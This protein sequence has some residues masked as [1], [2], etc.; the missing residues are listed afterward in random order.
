M[1]CQKCAIM[2]KMKNKKRKQHK[3]E[4]LLPLISPEIARGIVIVILF[5]FAV[6]SFLS[7][8]NSAGVAGFYLNKVLNIAFGW[9]KYLFAALCLG[10][11]YILT[12]P[13]KYPIHWH[14]YFG[15]LLLLLGVGGIIHLVEIDREQSFQ[16]VANGLGAGFVGFVGSYFLQTYFGMVASM[17]ILIAVVF[18]SII[19]AFNISLHKI[20]DKEFI[21][22]KLAALKSPSENITEPTGNVA[23]EVDD[24]EEYGAPA[25]QFVK[26]QLPQE[27]SV[28]IR[29]RK[30]KIDLPIDLLDN[31]IEKPRSGDVQAAKERI[32]KTLANFNIPVEMA[33]ISVGPTV[34][35]YTLKPA[36]GIKLSKITTLSSDLAL[37]LAAHPIRIEA[38]IPGKSLVGIEVPNQKIA[39]VHIRELL[40]NPD[41]KHRQ[42]SLTIALGKDVAGKPQFANL[43]K[44]PHLLI[45]GATGSGKSMGIHSMIIT[46]L[47][48][49]N[50]ETL[51]LLLVDPKR[52][53]FTAYNGIPHLLTPVITDVTKTINALRWAI[54]EMDR[55]FNILAK[56]HKRNVDSYNLTAAEKMPY[57]V[58]VIDE[59]ADLMVA[60]PAEVEACVIRLTQMARAVG[61]HLIIATQRPSVDVITGLIK[62]NMPTRIA[63]S[64]ASL[65][66]SRTILDGS[67]AEKLMGKGDML[68]MSPLLSKPKRLQGGFASD[69]EIKR[70]T[71]FLKDA[72][73]SEQNY[74]EEILEKQHGVSSMDFYS[75]A[76]D[77]DGDVLFNDAKEVVIQAGRA[78]ASLLQRRLRVGYA[79][80]ARLIDLM[81]AAGI[82]GPADGARPRDVLVDSLQELPSQR[83]YSEIVEQQDATPFKSRTIAPIQA[84]DDSD[85]MIEEVEEDEDKK[86]LEDLD[87]D[88][89]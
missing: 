29:P 62:A 64:V 55:R 57:I 56:N 72:S 75:S 38:P 73:G 33:D 8:V 89:I 16:A 83:I 22:E 40:E 32:Q 24:D 59:L 9:T 26:R 71:K 11:S 23:E 28:M 13:T 34:T 39:T 52:V 45:A 37:A 54:S 79:R 35:Q 65:I 86:L 68:F 58:I 25:A 21:A 66:D 3:E 27:Q 41:F 10:L 30:I 12:R 31:K 60:A 51:R 80:A 53:E 43:Q 2:H 19:L 47:Y 1:R 88:G 20:F 44:M 81:E 49:N 78:S 61:I 63:Y 15:M 74:Q 85:E 5:T 4:E 82:V 67:G 87:N 46:M 7:F 77:G 14:N 69:E 36:D 70:V 17:I 76:A 50:P 48:Q 42:S 18:G 84:I 6:I